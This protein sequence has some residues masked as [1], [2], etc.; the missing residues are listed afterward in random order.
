VGEVSPGVSSP[1]EQA[2][3]NTDAVRRQIV[4]TEI[5]IFSIRLL[6]RLAVDKS[7]ATQVC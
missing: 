4:Q 2:E 7:R 6:R 1:D 5:R 3:E